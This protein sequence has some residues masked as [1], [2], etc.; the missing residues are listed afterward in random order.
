MSVHGLSLLSAKQDCCLLAFPVTLPFKENFLLVSSVPGPFSC[1]ENEW[2]L[3]WRIERWVSQSL[4]KCVC[5]NVCEEGLYLC[6][7]RP[8]TCGEKK[9]QRLKKRRGKVCT[10]WGLEGDEEENL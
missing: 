1:R 8:S 10:S 4:C 2:R 6:L 5:V 7:K 3:C 9:K